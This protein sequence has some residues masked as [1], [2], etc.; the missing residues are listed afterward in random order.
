MARS[1]NC[2]D[3]EPNGSIKTVDEII[4]E[5]LFPHTDVKTYVWYQKGKLDRISPTMVNFGRKKTPRP[6]EEFVSAEQNIS[7]I[8]GRNSREGKQV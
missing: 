8:D 1:R 6:N 4:A 3:H 7:I 5:S 2:T